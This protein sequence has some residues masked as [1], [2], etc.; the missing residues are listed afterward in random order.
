MKIFRT[1]WT[2]IFATILMTGATQ[3]EDNPYELL[4]GVA[5]K[6]FAII[7]ER[8][9]EIQTN[10]D[11]LKEIVENELVPYVDYRFAGAKVLGRHFK[12]IAKDR[13]LMGAYFEEF[14]KYLISTYAVALSQ[15]DDQDVLFEPA[16]D[17]EDK[18][19]VTVRALIK[20]EGRPDIKIAFKVRKSSR[21]DEWKAYDMVAE[22]ISMLSS[23]S[24]EFE[25]VLR[26][27]GVEKVIE[28]MRSVNEKPMKLKT[29]ES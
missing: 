2:A 5:T 22:G 8:Q 21:T 17:Y 9:S 3:A 12:S 6:T 13:D 29:D 7:K 10:P 11:I 25:S 20:D 15:Y 18:K 28:I 4:Q 23:K 19:D 24:T 26:Q 16:K 1:I 27:D 14:R